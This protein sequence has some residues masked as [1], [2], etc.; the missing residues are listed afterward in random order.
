[1]A[2]IIKEEAYTGSSAYES[3]IRPLVEKW[4]KTKLPLVEQACNKVGIPF[5]TE[6]QFA[7]ARLYENTEQ[8]IKG[9][10]LEATQTSDIGRYKR[11]AI[12][13]I[14]AVVP[15]LTAFENV[16][17]EPLENKTGI[18]NYL[19]FTTGSAKGKTPLG[20]DLASPL[21]LGPVDPNYT[22]KV[23]SGEQLP[24]ATATAYE[25]TLAWIPVMPGSVVI[26]HGA[27]TIADDGSGVLSASTGLTGTGTIDYTT[28]EIS[29]TLTTDDTSSIPVVNYKYDNERIPHKRTP[30]INFKIVSETLE[31][32][33]RYLAAYYP[34]SGA[35][36]LKK[37]YGVEIETLLNVQATAEIQREI[38]ADIYYD[39]MN[40]AAAGQPLVWKKTPP[41]GAPISLTMHYQDFAI[42]LSEGAEQIHQATR[43]Y[44]GNRIVCGTGVGIIISQLQGFTAAGS[45]ASRIGAYVAGEINGM[46]VTVNPEF[47]MYEG[48]IGVKNDNYLEANYIYAPYMPILT[49]DLV[50]LAD[51]S[52]QKGWVTSDAKKM[53]NPKAFI[54]FSIV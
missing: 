39:I 25:A 5:T 54:K 50:T 49:T 53:I 37:E 20:A 6:R 9:E 15:N 30:Q 23:I 11:Y 40:Q 1:M 43:R 12:D 52:I 28:G 21:G 4:N 29:Y 45:S 47:P 10:L 46:K 18:V 17:V 34:L 51:T 8:F 32:E 16:T 31:A 7:L 19:K 41:Q 14:T 42:K 26:T 3:K 44:R 48:F 35:F 27:V 33:D 38:D 36:Q 24:A 2:R 22:S 13:L